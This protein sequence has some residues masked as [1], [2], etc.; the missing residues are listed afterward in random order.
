MAT[1]NNCINVNKV[2]LAGSGKDYALSI[3][4]L[5]ESLIRPYALTII[6]NPVLNVTIHMAT[7][8]NCINVSKS[9]MAAF[10][11]ILIEVDRVCI[12]YIGYTHG[13]EVK[14]DNIACYNFN[15]V[16]AIFCIL[17]EGVVNIDEGNQSSIGISYVKDTVLGSNEYVVFLILV[18]VS[19]MVTNVNNILAYLVSILEV[20][21][22]LG[23]ILFTTGANRT[24]AACTPR[25][26]DR[27]DSLR[28]S[29]CENEYVICIKL[30]FYS[31]VKIN[32]DRIIT[33]NGVREG[34]FTHY[35]TTGAKNESTVLGCGEGVFNFFKTNF[36]GIHRKLGLINPR[37]NRT[38]VRSENQ[39]TTIDVTNKSIG[40]HVISELVRN[41]VSIF[42]RCVNKNYVTEYKNVINFILSYSI[43]VV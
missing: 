8:S 40:S 16:D 18:Y 7:G 24:Y 17:S 19:I 37:S 1:G 13:P 12:G 6:A 9:V 41:R 35:S 43:A 25:C 28:S 14:C 33:V 5:S 15:S 22:N 3:G 34:Y 21:E 36:S 27:G 4:K 30:D 10:C 20:L 38:L 29:N 42:I 31:G 11:Y 32:T 39:F 23:R 26:S 2:T